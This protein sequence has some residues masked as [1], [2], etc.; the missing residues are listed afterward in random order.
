MYFFNCKTGCPL[1]LPHH[2][3]ITIIRKVCVDCQ[4]CARHGLGSWDVS[5][6]KLMYG[7]CPRESYT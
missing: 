1:S 2:K 7:L 6:N 4:L 3:I 5:V